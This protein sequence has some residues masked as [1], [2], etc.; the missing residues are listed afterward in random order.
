MIVMNLVTPKAAA[1]LDLLL[2]KNVLNGLAY[3]RWK[4]R[5]KYSK[6]ITLK[7]DPEFNLI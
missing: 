4:I 1:K 5:L 7:I 2:N 6:K 3:L